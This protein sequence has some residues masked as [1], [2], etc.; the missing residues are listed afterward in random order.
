MR[1]VMILVKNTLK[2]TFNKK[3]NLIV[4]LFLPIMGVLISMAIYSNAGSRPVNIGFVDND[5]SAF[6]NDIVK[7]MEDSG[8]YNISKIGNEEVKNKLLDSKLDAVIIIPEG[9]GRSVYENSLKSIEITSIKGQE[10]T[11][12]LQNYLNMYSQNLA[13]IATATEGDKDGFDKMYKNYMGNSLKLKVEKLADTRTNQ[14]VTVFS[15]GFLIMFTMLGAGF[16]SQFILKEKRD[17]TYYRICSAP[18]KFREY[19]AGNTITSLLIVSLQIIMIL[20]ALKYIFRIETYV[21][22]PLMFLILFLFGTVAIGIG[23]IIT[24]YSNS[25][26][27]SGTIS[28]LVMTPTCMLGGCFWPVEFMPE[29]M[30]KIAFFTPQWWTLDAIRKIQMGNGFENILINL[31]ILA[32][33]AAA[34]LMISIYRFS[35]SN[36][37]QKFV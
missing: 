13:A 35:R 34:L 2:V 15:M 4:Y 31:A 33:F 10:S 16:T 20:M 5:T 19:I 12:F 8:N 11:A 6:S 28:T 29:F 24:A 17:R 14:N 21:P 27:M 9:F 36:N 37:V 32:A 25:S 1:N 3:A 7:V 30:R 23:M 26:Y 18:V 22:A